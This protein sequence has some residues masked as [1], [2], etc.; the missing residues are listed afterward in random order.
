MSSLASFTSLSQAW[1]SSPSVRVFFNFFHQPLTSVVQLSVCVCLLQLLSP[2]SHKHGISFHLCVSS[3]TSFTSLSQAWCSSPSV[4]V[5]FNFFHQPLTSVV[6]L[7]ICVCLLY[8][9]SPASHKRGEA[10]HLCVPSL[11]SF[12][13]ILQF[14]SNSCFHHCIGFWHTGV[15]HTA[16]DCHNK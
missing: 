14:S 12:T 13:G 4:R 10:L 7:S 15:S 9:L 3:L 2:A 11:P 16:E 6:K 8:L 5:F 1:C